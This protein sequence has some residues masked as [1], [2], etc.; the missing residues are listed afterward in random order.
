[1]RICSQHSSGRK[2]AKVAMK[3]FMPTAAMPAA[4]D[5]MF[6]S[7]MPNCTKR[8]GQSSANFD[9]PLEYCRSAVP[10][11]T[12]S[13]CSTSSSSASERALRP[14]VWVFSARYCQ[15]FADKGPVFIQITLL[16]ISSMASCASCGSR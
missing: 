16:L 14:G 1:M 6:C 4:Q 8:S 5:T 10:A 13:P 2:E 15:E 12:G 9:R 11:T 3:G 7:E